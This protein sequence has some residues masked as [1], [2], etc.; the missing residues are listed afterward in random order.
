MA[1]FKGSKQQEQQA[2]SI[3]TALPPV[4]TEKRLQARGLAG[5]E[6]V[7]VCLNDLKQ[8]KLVTRVGMGKVS[9]AF[10]P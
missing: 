9:M 6:A 4:I 8:P 3:Q 10:A 5:P 7:W 2:A 1:R